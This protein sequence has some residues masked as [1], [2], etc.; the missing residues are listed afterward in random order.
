[1]HSFGHIEYDLISAGITRFAGVDE[2]GRGPLA[3]PVVAAAVMFDPGVIIEGVADSKVLSA[4]QRE[5]VAATIRE[6]AI[7]FGIGIASH[8]E[9]DAINILQATMLAMR[10]AITA[11]AHAPAFLLVD[12]N[13]FVHDGIP[14]RT[15]V[16]GDA[17]CFSIAAASILAKVERDAIMLRLDERYPQYGFARH[18]GYPTAAHV[19]AISEF[20]PCEIH[21]RSFTVKSIS[22]QPGIFTDERSTGTRTR[23]RGARSPA[24]D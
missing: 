13:R 19:A 1:M 6:K 16:K 21:R 18:K 3:G 2:A 23:G 17:L 4:I 5:T 15:V 10:R 22:E 11:M 7:S 20:G 9:I 12:G 24:S 8:E 14:F